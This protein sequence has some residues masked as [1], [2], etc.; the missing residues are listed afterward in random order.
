MYPSNLSDA[1]WQL[2]EPLVHY[3]D[4]AT[5]IPFPITLPA[6]NEGTQ[7]RV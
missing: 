5:E 6:A 1:E 7:V 4:C 2:I 3:S